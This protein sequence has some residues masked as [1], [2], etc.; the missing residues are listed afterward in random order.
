MI[1]LLT[2]K[3]KNMVCDRCIHVVWQTLLDID[4]SVDRVE[5]GTVYLQVPLSKD[6]QT[7][8]EQ[9]LGALGFEI[10]NDKQKEVVESVKNFIHDKFQNLSM[11]TWNEN[12][13]DQLQKHIGKDYSYVSKL[14]SLTE[15]V[16]IEKFLSKQKIEKSKELI[17]YDEM[18]LAEIA[19]LLGFSSSQYL[20]SKFKQTIGLTPSEF[21]KQMHKPMRKSLD[22]I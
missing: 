5:L 13:S 20:S 11:T 2:L 12:F 21:K 17:S 7:L 18:S 8:L 10:L 1:D 16:T 4:A 22:E 14:F 6:Q 9:K 19:D 3:I 15:G